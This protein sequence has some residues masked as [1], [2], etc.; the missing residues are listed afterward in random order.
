MSC[1]KEILSEVLRI[2]D[3]MHIIMK[4]T[5]SKWTKEDL[6]TIKSHLK[7]LALRIPALAVL[8]APGGIVLLPIL[9]EVLNRRKTPKPVAREK[10]SEPE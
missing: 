2:D 4:G 9:A 3:L 6:S 10:R 1:R 8:L 7:H 5:R